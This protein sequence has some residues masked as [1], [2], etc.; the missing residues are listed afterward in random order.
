M[1][2]RLFTRSSN[3]GETLSAAISVVGEQD[4]YTFSV[5]ANDGVTIRARKTSGNLTPYLS[6]YGPGV[7][8]ITSAA[9]QIDRVITQSGTYT[10]FVLCV[11]FWLDVVIM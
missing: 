8:L 11:S 2:M 4:S 1:S 3:C 10:M 7:G 5:S 9:A 6:L